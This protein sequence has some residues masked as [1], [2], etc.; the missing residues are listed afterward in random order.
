MSAT[1]SRLSPRSAKKVGPK[2]AARAHKA[3][4]KPAPGARAAK[5]RQTRGEQ[6][7]ALLRRRGGA[8]IAELMQV[9][10]LLGHT[11]R[12]VI[13]VESRKQGAKVE[14]PENG[15]YHIAE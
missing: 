12:A 7:L 11:I 1:K 8:T 14:R 9:T 5:P 15:R 10:G 4:K 2:P 13:S 3:P 6:V